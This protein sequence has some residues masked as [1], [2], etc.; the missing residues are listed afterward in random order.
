MSKRI[1]LLTFFIFSSIQGLASELIVWNVGQGQWITEVDSQVCFHY[2]IG[3]EFNPLQ[4]VLKI[5]RGKINLVHLSHL[6]W[7]HFSFYSS[8]LRALPETCLIQRPVGPASPAKKRWLEKIPLCLPN[9]IPLIQERQK[10]LFLAKNSRNSNAS[11]QVV[12]SQK[13]R[14]LIPGDSPQQQEKLWSQKIPRSTEG[15]IL[16]HHGSRTSNSP[17]LFSS[18]PKIRWAVASA[19]R[20]RYG[21]PHWQIVERLKKEKVPLLKTEDWGHLHFFKK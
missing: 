12:W 8:L 10:S 1:F 17:R 19:R 20:G 3:G 9:R 18:L 7:D 2:D 4:R 16:G 5:C 14:V 6:D 13:F 21:H 11:S 15:W